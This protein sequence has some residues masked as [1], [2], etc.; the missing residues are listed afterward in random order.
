MRDPIKPLTSNKGERYADATIRG[1]EECWEKAPL[2]VKK[3]P[4]T[5]WVRKHS[6]QIIDAAGDKTAGNLKGLI[7][8]MA[9]F[10]Q[11]DELVMG[12]PA[13]NLRYP[14]PKESK[15]ANLVPLTEAEEV[16]QHLDLL[17][18]DKEYIGTLFYTGMR[19][20]EAWALHPEDVDLQAREIYVHRGWDKVTG[21]RSKT[22]TG[23]ERRI[24]ILDGLYPLLVQPGL[25][26]IERLIMLE[27]EGAR[28]VLD[29]LGDAADPGSSANPV[30]RF[31]PTSQAIE[32]LRAGI[33]ANFGEVG[34]WE[35]YWIIR[36]LHGKKWTHSALAP[37]CSVLIPP[38]RKMTRDGRSRSQ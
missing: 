30:G 37:R 17:G 19:P 16:L 26:K 5:K 38:Q 7:G 27:S 13:S 25:D 22:K 2:N 3:V 23:A 35:R 11:R 6:Q 32:S 12:N 1:Y 34:R 31:S 4:I 29:A 15:R 24:K 14:A 10:A 36:A 9:R 8:A 28:F 20:S 21:E 18:R 33:R